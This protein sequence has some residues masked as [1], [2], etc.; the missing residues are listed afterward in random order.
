MLRIAVLAILAWL[1]LLTCAS[2]TPE[3][4][5]QR[6]TDPYF[7]DQPES[8]PICAKDYNGI[9]SCVDAAPIFQ[10]FTNVIFNPG[11]FLD[12]MQCACTDTFK[13]VFPQ[14]VD[15]FIRTGQEHVLKGDDLPSVVQ[16]LRQVCGTLS[17][18]MGN[19]TQNNDAPPP[20]APTSGSTP[21]R[22][23]AVS[24]STLAIASGISI[25]AASMSIWL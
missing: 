4:G 25:V 24:L 12:A 14:C 21:Y 9:R 7:P 20:A 19:V 8:C 6:R 13:A 2:P 5:L 10:N 1:T 16:G 18:L 11:A 15:C 3:P 23:Q 17:T 22:V